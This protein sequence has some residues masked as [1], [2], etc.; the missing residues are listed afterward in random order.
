MIYLM[1]V[2]NFFTCIKVTSLIILKIY[3][4]ILL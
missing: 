1:V 3:Q 4:Q 2:K